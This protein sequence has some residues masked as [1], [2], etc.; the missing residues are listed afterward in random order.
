MTTEIDSL[1]ES[2]FRDAKGLPPFRTDRSGTI[3]GWPTDMRARV[4]N[5]ISRLAR[6][7][8]QELRDAI[9]VIESFDASELPEGLAPTLARVAWD[10]PMSPD[11]VR[12]LVARKRG[13]GLREA[14]CEAAAATV[15]PK[16]Q[17]DRAQ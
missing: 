12:F 16:G 4:S 6:S 13:V 17:G 14:L 8:A 1:I 11:P 5:I 9:L 15:S 2:L 10:L 3:P 7:S